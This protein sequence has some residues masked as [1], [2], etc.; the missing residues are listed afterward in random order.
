MTEKLNSNDQA[1]YGETMKA[2]IIAQACA[3]YGPGYSKAPKFDVII[4][5]VKDEDN[6]DTAVAWLIVYPDTRYFNWKPLL[7][8]AKYLSVDG[9]YLSLRQM[10]RVKTAEV[11]EKK[12]KTGMEVQPESECYKLYVAKMSCSTHN[13]RIMAGMTKYETVMWE[14]Q[15]EEQ[16]LAR[17]DFLFSNMFPPGVVF[18]ISIYGEPEA[19][20]CD[21][22]WK[23]G[24]TNTPWDGLMRYKFG[25]TVET[26]LEKLLGYLR[27]QS[28]E[29]LWSSVQSPHLVESI[30]KAQEDHAKAEEDLKEAE[31]VFKKAVEVLQKSST[32]RKKAGVPEEVFS[33]MYV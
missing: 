17:I 13:L 28:V 2:T 12:D 7:Q 25:D 11:M 10:L 33:S 30:K 21:I 20:G 15:I 31:E 6:L 18:N 3:I 23:M 8:T 4:G 14:K 9:A 26:I 29:D 16:I 5:C 27:E 32:D 19:Y 22:N 24:S 1:Q